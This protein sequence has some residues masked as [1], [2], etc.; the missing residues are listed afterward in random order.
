MAPVLL[1]AEGA[2]PPFSVSEVFAQARL[3]TWVA[4]GIVVVGALYLYGVHRLHARSDGW[5][6]LRTVLFLG[7]GLGGIAAVT[8]TG[9][10]A[11]D[12]TLLSVHMVQHMVL[13]MIAP[14]FLAL[15]APITLA[16]RTLRGAPR[17]RL[18]AV[19]HSRV[20]KVLTFPLV[21]FGLFV[22]TPF[23]LYFTG[24]YRLTLEHEWLH[25]LM[26]LHFIVVGCLFFWPLI[27]LDPLP[28]R[29]PYPARAL[30]MLLS[31]PFHTVLGLTVMQ[32]STL[33]GGDWYPSL[34]LSWADP[35]ADQQVAGGILWA[36]GEFVSITMLAV[37]VVQWMRA[38]ER[39]ARRVDRELDRQEAREAA[40]ARAA[41]ADAGS[42]PDATP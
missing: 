5:P 33:L 19:I 36:G 3:D 8:V 34:H 27:G 20:A 4:V 29:W 17:R 28:G 15:G 13:S 9:I 25:E 7:P 12:T 42:A 37:L 11:Y 14:I 38:S 39:E 18:L 1:S 24:L 32:S 2:P 23:A 30:L 10:A 41:A 31:V 40:A 21:S 22:A 35:F 16:L 26:H 6:V